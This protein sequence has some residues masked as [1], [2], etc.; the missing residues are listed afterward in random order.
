MFVDAV[1]HGHSSPLRQTPPGITNAIRVRRNNE[2]SREK[3][4]TSRRHLSVLGEDVRGRMSCVLYIRLPWIAIAAAAMNVA[5]SLYLLGDG[6]GGADTSA[7]TI[8]Y[9]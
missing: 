4:R 9:Y 6:G 8:F 3:G 7:F 1:T 5:N 2:Y